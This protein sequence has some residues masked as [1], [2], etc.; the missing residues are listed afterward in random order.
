[1]GSDVPRARPTDATD[2]SIRFTGDDGW[3][4]ESARRTLA[5][6][7]IASPSAVAASPSFMA[8]SM[9]LR[10]SSS[11]SPSSFSSPVSS[12]G[13]PM[14]PRLLR[15]LFAPTPP[16]EE[17]EDFFRRFLTPTPPPP[18]RSPAAPPRG[19]R[20]GSAAGVDP[21]FILPGTEADAT[22]ARRDDRDAEHDGNVATVAVVVVVVAAVAAAASRR[23][24]DAHRIVRANHREATAAAA[25]RDLFV[26]SGGRISGRIYSSATIPEG[27]GTRSCRRICWAEV[28]LEGGGRCEGILQCCCSAD[29]RGGLGRK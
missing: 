15:F 14:L 9:A 19:T 17:E 6:S 2:A 25:R 12:E 7:R 29:R 5:R 28:R 1:M 20:S 4:V 18:P 3:G 23:R 8:A 27:A 16:P 26:S 21:R 11:P 13:R 10:P 24:P 22:T